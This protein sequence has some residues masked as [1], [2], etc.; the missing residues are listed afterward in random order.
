[1]NA[2]GHELPN[3]LGVS[4]EGLEEKIRALLPG[5]MAMEESG[6]AEHAEHAEH[7]PGPKNTLPM[8]M[9]KGPFGNIEMGGMFTII[10]VRDGLKSYDEDPGWYRHPEGTV[11]R[12]LR[13]K[14]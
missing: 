8:M 10:K 11:A 4:Q 9:G 1:M 12:R 2:M 14:Q 3:L 13:T 6:M 5:Y 7:M